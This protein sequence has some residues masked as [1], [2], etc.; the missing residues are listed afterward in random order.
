MLDEIKARDKVRCGVNPGLAGFAAKTERGE[1]Q[2][3]DID[4]CRAVAAAALGDT[5]KVIIKDLPVKDGLTALKSGEID[6]LT[7]N[8]A[9]TMGRETLFGLSFAG[10]VFHD[11]QGFLVRKK[12]GIVSALELSGT[13]VCT[14]SS[15]TATAN[16][17]E[18]F[19]SRQMKHEMISFAKPE[20]VLQAY[21]V[22]RCQVVA[23]D[24]TQLN[25][26][27]LRLPRPEE[28]LVLPE[29]FSKE[30]LGPVVRQGDDQWA[31]LVKWTI[32]ALVNAEELGV[33][34]ANAEAMRKSEVP[35]IR[36]LL[37]TEG[38][39]GKGLG[40]D[41]DWAYRAIKAVGNYG[42][43]YTRNLGTGSPLNI[44]R[45]VNNLWNRGGILYAPPIR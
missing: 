1:W 43:I 11:G 10:V 19:R 30:P 26:M 13:T 39:F 45:G 42:E 4:I 29:I 7:R 44:P 16:A 18:F 3:L 36:R 35:D 22:G 2:G 40:L 20:E 6:L 15:T 23:A 31:T 33:T 12:L 9:W 21:E 8:L 41:Q 37:G 17:T 32:Y 5:S 25:A 28:H 38:D 14:Q 27:R 34:A 24:I